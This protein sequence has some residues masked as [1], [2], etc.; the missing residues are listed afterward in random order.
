ML[1]AQEGCFLE[2]SVTMGDPDTATVTLTL[3]VSTDSSAH[4][5]LMSFCLMT[6]AMWRQA[7]TEKEKKNLMSQGLGYERQICST[8]E[9]VTE[10]EKNKI[11]KNLKQS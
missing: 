9:K 8:M 6:H 3:S 11:K 5:C 4:H 1:H 10:R 7:V 2:D